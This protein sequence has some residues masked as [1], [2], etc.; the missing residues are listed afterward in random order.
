M[1]LSGVIMLVLLSAPVKV[2]AYLDPGNGSY[3]LQIM[4]AS[5]LGVGVA[6]KS[7][8]TKIKDF[9]NKLLKRVRT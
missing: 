7:Y 3:V 5:L 2:Y 4:I 9:F 6:V 8:W 1:F